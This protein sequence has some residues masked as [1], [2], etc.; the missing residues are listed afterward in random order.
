MS[1]KLLTANIGALIP[2]IHFVKALVLLMIKIARVLRID[3][4]E[5]ILNVPV[6]VQQCF[7]YFFGYAVANACGSTATFFGDRKNV[8]VGQMNLC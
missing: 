3:V 4:H 1:G 2:G 5:S 8:S 7:F 6:I